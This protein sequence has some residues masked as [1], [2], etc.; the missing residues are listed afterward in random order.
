M[1]L[2]EVT[3]GDRLFISILFQTAFGEPGPFRTLEALRADGHLPLELVALDAATDRIVG[4]ISFA[5]LIAPE[6]W[7]TL[8][9]IAVVRDRQQSGI[10]T[11]ILRYGLDR[12][13]QARAQAIVVAGGGHLARFG[14]SAKA[15]EKLSLPGSRTA[16]MLFP[17][18]AGTAGM[19]ATLILPDALSTLRTAAE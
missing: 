2:R 9:P 6:G 12:A 10:E 17:I 8:L 19:R 15:A 13:R 4:H 11:E 5:S 3:E 1:K 7:W 16:L 18:A 14:F